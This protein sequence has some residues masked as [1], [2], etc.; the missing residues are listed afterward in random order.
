[1]TAGMVA[2]RRLDGAPTILT[3]VAVPSAFLGNDVDPPLFSHEGIALL[4]IKIAEGRIA[5]MAPA[6]SMEGGIDLGGRQLWPRLVDMHTHLD[7]SHVYARVENPDFTIAG[8]REATVRDR[9]L[10]W[11]R[12]DLERRIDF[13]LRAAEHYGV[14]AIR[15][16]LDSLEHL[17][18]ASWALFSDIRQAWRQRI[19]LQAVSLVPLEVY[20]TPY[21]EH[22]AELVAE[23]DGVL[24]GVTIGPDT[25]TAE[26]RD[27]LRRR[28]RCLFAL[29][30]ANGL[31]LDLHVDETGDTG[32]QTLSYVAE[33]ILETGFSG[34]VACGHCCSLALCD[35][36]QALA[37]IGLLKQAGV[38]IITLPLPNMHLQDR[39]GSRTPRWRG[40]PPVKELLDGGVPVAIAGDNCRDA[41]FSYGD[42][43][44]VD[45]LRQGSRILHLDDRLS[46]ALA[47]AG[48][49]PATLMGLADAGR[50]RVGGPADFIVFD[51]RRI[52]HIFSRP[53]T[54]RVVIREGKAVNTSLPQ[55]EELDDLK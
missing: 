39:S 31:D 34:K 6:G 33:G 29:A 43:D 36:D 9:S 35:D 13:S 2:L 16:H 30:Q 51:A 8:A 53:Q 41:W 19:E 18:A 32:L 4:D 17:S 20:A 10:N 52:N 25:S 50:I 42:G 22:L 49:V 45:T 38:A 5:A 46:A 40:V 23:H 11:T 7:K 55:Y 37:T 26:G 21:G 12:G 24:G 15:T 27:L 44:M 14:G 1:M 54:A 47:M 28:L 3:C 48:P